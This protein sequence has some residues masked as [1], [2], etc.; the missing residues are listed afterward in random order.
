MDQISGGYLYNRYLVE[1][2][3]AEGMD[4]RYHPAWGEMGS[5]QESDVLVVDSL[6]VPEWAEALLST[7]ASLVLLLHVVPEATGLSE[8]LLADLYRRSRVV[9]TG[10]ST[11]ATLR[12]TLALEG[13]DAVKIEPGVPEHWR[14]KER[15]AEQARALL[16]VANYL[17]G[18]G[19]RRLIEALAPLRDLG[20]HLTV[21]GNHEF[22]P[23]HYRMLCDLVAELGLED[24]IELTGPVPHDAVNQEM[25]RSDLLVHFSDHESYSMV[26]AEAIAS[27]LP[28]LSY[29]TGAAD[30]FSRSGLV[31][32]VD[33]QAEEHA[34]RRL[35]AQPEAY[36]RL[37]RA[38]PR[39]IRTW[40]DVG[41]DFLEWLE[42]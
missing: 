38:G 29:R 13:V 6:V 14:E 17:P 36:G 19:I 22:A 16:G 4:V 8:S 20:W 25:I 2:M 21:R 9:V 11:L 5:V 40:S 18:K 33:T 34:L 7:R 30:A 37:R 23:D 35:I 39:Q 10:N 42:A 32:H 3:R 15:Y 31:H 27:G 1:H 26:T 12:G 28:V 24:R 41:T